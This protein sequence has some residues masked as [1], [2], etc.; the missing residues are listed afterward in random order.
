MS[1]HGYFVGDVVHVQIGRVVPFGALIEPLDGFDGLIVTKAG[2]ESGSVV[3]VR[4][5]EIDEENRRMRLTRA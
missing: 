4:I 1:R 5:A 3:R 2:L